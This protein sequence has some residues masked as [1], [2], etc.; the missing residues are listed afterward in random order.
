MPSL[1]DRAFEAWVEGVAREEGNEG[2]LPL[3]SRMGSV[4]VDD[5]LKARD[6]PCGLCRSGSE[7]MVVRAS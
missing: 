6:T 5:G 4:F 2:S 1:G 3:I 7:F